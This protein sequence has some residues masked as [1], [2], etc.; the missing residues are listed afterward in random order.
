MLIFLVKWV[1]NNIIVFIFKI[2][3]F[4]FLRDISFTT[5]PSLTIIIAR[6][7]TESKQKNLELDKKIKIWINCHE[8]SFFFYLYDK[9]AIHCTHILLE[10]ST[11]KY[12]NIYLK[13][14]SFCSNHS[15]NYSF[16]QP[17]NKK[18]KDLIIF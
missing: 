13:T 17:E 15:W 8:I 5:A 4:I 1:W 3:Y 7:M 16:S 18:W 6:R 12:E 14:L 9:K 10:K 2:Q 11:I